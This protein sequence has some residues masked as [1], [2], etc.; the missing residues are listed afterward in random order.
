MAEVLQS[1]FCKFRQAVE[2]DVCEMLSYRWAML[3]ELLVG[4]VYI[5]A[6]YQIGRNVLL[7]GPG[8]GGY[9]EYLLVSMCFWAFYNQATTG[10]LARA[11]HELLIGTVKAIMCTRTSLVEFLCY[12]MVSSCLESTARCAAYLVVAVALFEYDAT[13]INVLSSA[14]VLAMTILSHA[15]IGLAAAAVLLIIKKG[16]PMLAVLGTGAMWLL[17]GGL[18]PE[19]SLP[20]FL[21]TLA[22]ALPTTHALHAFRAAMVEGASLSALRAD[23]L[24]L[25]G[26]TLVVLPV[27]HFFSRACLRL[28]R[29]LGSID[30]Y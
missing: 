10:L 14:V 9:F 16:E 12:C 5:F 18:Y 1:T 29:R 23:L 7:N 28:A 15:P 30:H 25:V 11:R 27:T 8:K 3:L 24:W 19:S 4:A 22:S 20:H 2:R 17:S 13:Q 26:F 6:A 21:Q